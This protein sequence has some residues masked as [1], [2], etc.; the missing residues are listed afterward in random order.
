MEPAKDAEEDDLL[1]D[2]A[3]AAVADSQGP[4]AVDQA[5]AQAS[6]VELQPPAAPRTGTGGVLIRESNAS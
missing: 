2:D 4:N 3:D 6:V 1:E 5:E